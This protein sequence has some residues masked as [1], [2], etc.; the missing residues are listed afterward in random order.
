MLRRVCSLI[1]N[2][3]ADTWPV[4]LHFECFLA[5]KVDRIMPIHS[6][7]KLSLRRDRLH[8][9]FDPHYMAVSD[10]ATRL[11]NFSPYPQN[12][13]SYGNLSYLP[14]PMLSISFLYRNH[15]LT[16]PSHSSLSRCSSLV[17]T[18]CLLVSSISPARNTSSNI[19]YTL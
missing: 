15:A 16:T 19:A 11:N 10:I 18:T 13:S 12:L 5:I 8:T 17:S 1:M 2:H 4:L 9:A 6:C 7:S 3:L 14:N